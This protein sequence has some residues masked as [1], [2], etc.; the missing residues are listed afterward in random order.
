V[1][2]AS[3]L[4]KLYRINVLTVLLVHTRAINLMLSVA[5][6]VKQVLTQQFRLT[7]V[8]IVPKVSTAHLARLLAR[9]VLL[10]S[11]LLLYKL[12]AARRALLARFRLQLGHGIARLVLL[13]ATK[14]PQVNLSVDLV[15][16]VSM[17]PPM[18]RALA[19]VVPL[20]T[21]AMMDLLPVSLLHQSTISIMKESALHVQG[22]LSAM[23]DFMLLFHS[24][25]IGL[26]IGHLNMLGMCLIVP[27]I[28]AVVVTRTIRAGTSSLTTEHLAQSQVCNALKALLVLCVALV[29]MAI[30]I[31]VRP[32]R[33][34]CVLMPETSPILR[35]EVLCSCS[36]W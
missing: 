12:Q 34:A 14:G 26:I 25:A 11:M 17:R 6:P 8:L 24:P 35:W 1:N 5:L 3:M 22:T 19:M 28:H 16:R 2:V 29:W 31:E 32:T 4:L 36:S 7:S 27:E 30:Y 15:M 13:D 10:V 23:V 20:D 33:V 9:L 18:V 21:I